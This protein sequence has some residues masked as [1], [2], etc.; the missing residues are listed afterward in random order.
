MSVIDR[1]LRRAGCYSLQARDPS[2]KGY[3]ASRLTAV[4]WLLRSGLLVALHSSCY[5]ARSGE[6][7][8]KDRDAGVQ[9][10]TVADGREG[11]VRGWRT[12]Q[13]DEPRPGLSPGA[14][15]TSEISPVGQIDTADADVNPR[16]ASDAGATPDAALFPPRKPLA[17]GAHT[18]ADA[19][20]ADASSD[21]PVVVPTSSGCAGAPALGLCW[22][23]AEAGTPCRAHCSRHGGFDARSARFVGTPA[24]GGD[25][26]YCAA[27][28][29]ALNVKGPL[30]PAFRPD[31]LGLGCHRWSDGEL[32]WVESPDEALF[33]Q[34]SFA[35][36]AEL[37]CACGR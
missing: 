2:R 11:P 10:V 20:T 27:V 34:D 14:P 5:V 8:G 31:G 33:T 4:R 1:A 15:T 6:S 30:Y 16:S 9:T 24:Q 17:A 23:L 12:P 35:E 22:Y 18:F 3:C 7:G 26:S 29:A 25:V 37:T 32:F 36:N 13:P 21:Q 19:A 28:F